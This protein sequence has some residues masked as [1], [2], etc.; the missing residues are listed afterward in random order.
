M[1]GIPGRVARGPRERLPFHPVDFVCRLPMPLPLLIFA[2][3]IVG[4][5]HKRAAIGPGWAVDSAL[6][7]RDVELSVSLGRPRVGF[8][9]GFR[10]G[11][12]VGFGVGFGVWVRGADWRHI[13][14]FAAKK[15]KNVESVNAEGTSLTGN[16]FKY[17][18][19]FLSMILPFLAPCGLR[20][21][22]CGLRLAACEMGAIG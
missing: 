19:A 18:L 9:F 1:L 4:C 15:R 20:L 5:L 12:R 2:V 21:A 22:P 8:E 3:S 7:S 11:F 14:F 13:T 6:Y 10:F 16:P 17:S